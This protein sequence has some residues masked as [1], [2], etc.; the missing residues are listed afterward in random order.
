V[1]HWGA[2]L[3]E[4]DVAAIARASAEPRVG[5]ELDERNA[6]SV[7]P[8]HSWGWMHTPG[9]SGSRGGRDGFT[10]FSVT[11]V[12]RSGEGEGDAAIQRVTVRAAD[13][14]A[15]LV[16]TVTIELLGSGLARA[17]AAVASTGNGSGEAAEP[18]QVEQLTVLFPVPREATEL[19]DF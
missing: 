6:L 15:E 14:V 2:E 10:R 12:E 4:G 9:L 5:G 3:G 11:S 17:R 8:E 1:V 7:L 16:L 18:Y 19:L 13:A